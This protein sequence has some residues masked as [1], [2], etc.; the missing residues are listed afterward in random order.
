MYV[1]VDVRSMDRM[2]A[3]HQLTAVNRTCASNMWQASCS[4]AGACI[5]CIT[6]CT[7]A[8]HIRIHIHMRQLYNT[9]LTSPYLA[10]LTADSMQIQMQM[11][12]HGGGLGAQLDCRVKRS[13]E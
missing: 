10:A 3:D 11:Q 2:H 12:M 13:R 6:L 4:T 9:H 1:D 5:Y 8:I 7:Y